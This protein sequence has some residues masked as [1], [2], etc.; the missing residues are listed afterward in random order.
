MLLPKAHQR[1]SVTRARVD[2]R[3][4]GG[5]SRAPRETYRKKDSCYKAEL[6]SLRKNPM[7]ALV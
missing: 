1:Y 4:P 2:G 3:V 5:G 7:F 6:L